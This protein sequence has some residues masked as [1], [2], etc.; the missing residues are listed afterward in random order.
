MSPTATQVEPTQHHRIS[1]ASEYEADVVVESR[2]QTAENVVTL[3]LR[4]VG[5]HPLPRWEPGAH[6]DLLLPDGL[7]RQYSLCGDPADHHRWRIGVLREQAGRGG[8]AFVHDQLRAGAPVRIRGPRNHFPIVAAPRYLFIAGGIGIT[9]IL[10]MIAAA[11]AAG[12]GWELVYGGRSRASMAFLD[13]LA[14]YGDRVTIRPQDETGLLDLNT[15]L[16][17]PRPGTL[18]YCC[19]PEPLLRAVEARCAGWSKGSLHVERFTAK[20]LTEP[21]RRGAFEVV[22]R[23]SDLTLTVPPDR[24]VLDVVEDAGVGV[25]SSCSEGTCGT[26][27]TPVL[28]GEP[29]HRDSVLTEDEHAANDCMMICVSRSRSAR[30]VL[31]L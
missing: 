24:S 26:C 9:P 8:S 11:E 20:P 23:Q 29:D 14:H 6:I 27:E 22:L 4:E 2:E 12:A 1:L 17:T 10:P 15:L 28:D 7:H 5:D 13:D 16:G 18:V 19:G 25:L 31:D 3:T 21:V 30:L